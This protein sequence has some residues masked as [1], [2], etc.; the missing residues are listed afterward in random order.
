MISCVLE[1]P[2]MPERH[3]GQ[4]IVDKLVEMVEKWGIIEKIAVVVHGQASNINIL[5]KAHGWL[6]MKCSGHCLQ[7]CVNAGLSISTIDRLTGAASKL[8]RHFKHSVVASEELKKR[9]PKQLIQKGGTQHTSVSDL[10]SSVFVPVIGC[11]DIHA[12][13]EI[14]WS[15][16]AWLAL[17]L[18]L[19]VTNDVI[20][21]FSTFVVIVLS[22]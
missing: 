12:F 17:S 4:N 9:Q 16:K 15:S 6:G 22:L 19:S 10:L 1:T 21:C 14:F 7:L 11:R 20:L 8:L 13:T 3:T 5:N 18:T 2:D